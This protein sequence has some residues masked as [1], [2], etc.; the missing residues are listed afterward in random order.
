MSKY[1]KE[2]A[3]NFCGL[4]VTNKNSKEHHVERNHRISKGGVTMFVDEKHSVVNHSCDLCAKQFNH[5]G[6]LKRH[7]ESYHKVF[8]NN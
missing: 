6:H 1:H 3:C 7:K 2:L 4:K 8:L 5:K